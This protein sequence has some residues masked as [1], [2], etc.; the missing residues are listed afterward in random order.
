MANKKFSAAEAK[1]LFGQVLDNAIA[2]DTVSITRYGEVKAVMISA[3]KYESLT[4]GPSRKLNMLTEHFDAMLAGM[5]TA[6]A[7]RGM[8]AAFQASPKEMGRNAVKTAR[9]KQPA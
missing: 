9:R 2:G 1:N 7:R 5:Q 4:Q 6:K 3:E 8:K